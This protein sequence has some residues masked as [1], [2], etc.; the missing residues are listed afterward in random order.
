MFPL[1]HF[2]LNFI[3]IQLRVWEVKNITSSLYPQCIIALWIS[4]RNTKCYCYNHKSQPQY[5]N[6]Q[7]HNS[8]NLKHPCQQDKPEPQSRRDTSPWL[9]TLL[10]SGVAAGSAAVPTP[11]GFCPGDPLPRH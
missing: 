7:H 2:M 4:V 3:I 9:Y 11:H 6:S 10:R 5:I 1:Q 8:A